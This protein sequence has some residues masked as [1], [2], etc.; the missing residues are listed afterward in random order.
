MFLAAK[1]NKTSFKKRFTAD[2]Y[3]FAA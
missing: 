2:K 3:K 1:C